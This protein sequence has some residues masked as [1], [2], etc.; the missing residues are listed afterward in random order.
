MAD[1]KRRSLWLLGELLLQAFHDVRRDQTVYVA[2]QSSNL[3]DQSRGRVEVRRARHQKNRLNLRLHAP[4][5]QRHLELEV[6]MI[7]CTKTTDND[8]CLQSINVVH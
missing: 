4:V 8:V 2:I 7:N 5:H 1:K 6:E 3:F